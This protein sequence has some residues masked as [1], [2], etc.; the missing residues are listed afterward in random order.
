MQRAKI[1]IASVLK[2]LK[3]PRAYYKMALSLRETSKY[4]LNIIGF[5]AKKEIE[6]DNIKFTPLFYQK[7]NSIARLSAGIRFL[8]ELFQYRPRV[9]IV[10]TYELLPAA[11]FA[12]VILKFKLVYDVQE[13]YSF[14]LQHNHTVKGQKKKL[15]IHAVQTI[16]AFAKNAIDLYI[17]AEAC[18]VHEFPD[19][20]PH[21][22][23]ENK[24]AYPNLTQNIQKTTASTQRKFLITGT[25]TPAFGSLDGIHWFLRFNQKY[26]NNHLTIIGHAPMRNFRDELK[27]L[28]KKHPSISFEISDLPIP[29]SKIIAAISVSEILLL[30]YR[31][32]PSIAPKRPSKLFEGCALGRVILHTPNSNWKSQVDTHTQGMEIDFLSDENLDQAH[33]FLMEIK[34]SGISSDQQVYWKSIAQTFLSG[35]AEL[36]R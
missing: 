30:P 12:K 15:A 14:N 13:N 11:V 6:E 21:I 32:H 26:P 5:S 23:L 8:K 22:V 29:Y 1:V 35:I 2:P 10:T 16:E 3:D 20:S 36:V 18:Y 4:H 24:M 33:E 7:R 17:F 27:A 31:Q 28:V 19:W 9:V 34:P 25:L